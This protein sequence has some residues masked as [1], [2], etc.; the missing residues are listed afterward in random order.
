MPPWLSVVFFSWFSLLASAQPY[1]PVEQE[2]PRLLAH[3]EVH[4]SEELSRLLMRAE[5]L[6]ESG[7]LV[8]GTDMPVA[9]VLHGAEAR[10]LIS[11]NYRAN[12]PLVDLAARL[13]AFQVVDISVCKTWMGGQGLDESQ[14]PPFIDTVPSGPA[15][16]RRLLEEQGYV[17]F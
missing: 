3:I 10:A 13:S 6:F 14:L 8:P 9:F 15:E 1:I 16:E 11:G 7:K 2:S 4:T 17:Y 12:K 5:Q